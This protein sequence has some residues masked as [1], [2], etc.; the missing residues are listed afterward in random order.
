MECFSLCLSYSKEFVMSNVVSVTDRFGFLEIRN[1]RDGDSYS[2]VLTGELDLS[3]TQDVTREL[4]LAEM[5]DARR[6]VLDLSG[7]T[8][9]DSSGVRMIVEAHER[10]RADGDR[11]ALT[12]AP[13]P[14]QRIFDMTDLSDRLPFTA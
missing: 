2:I 14:V 10:S 8:F 7:V 4:R 1:E 11:L 9:I 3:G 12:L 13:G 6:I 5:S